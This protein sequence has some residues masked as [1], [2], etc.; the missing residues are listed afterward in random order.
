MI[1]KAPP[2]LAQC[3]MSMS[4][5]N[6]RLSSRAQLMRAGAPYA[7]ASSLEVSGARSAGLAT[8]FLRN[9]ALGSQ[10]AVEA[11]HMETR[12]RHQRSQNSSGSMTIWVSRSLSSISFAF[13]KEFLLLRKSGSL[14][15]GQ[16]RFFAYITGYGRCLRNAEQ[17]LNDIHQV[18]RCVKR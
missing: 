16:A 12:P 9:F 8:T 14:A 13:L 7:W 3:S 15:M 5:W 18:G 4:M 1:F 17:Q 2:Q 10:H 6:T 11:D